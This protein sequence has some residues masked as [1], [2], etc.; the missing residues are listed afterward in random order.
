MHHFDTEAGVLAPIS[1]KIDGSVAM[2][3]ED[4]NK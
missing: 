1:E 4:Q 3:F 2:C